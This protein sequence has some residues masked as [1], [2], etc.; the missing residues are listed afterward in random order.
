MELRPDE[1]GKVLSGERG[2]RGSLCIGHCPV[3]VLKWKHCLGSWRDWA[4]N[5]RPGRPCSFSWTD[6]TQH[7]VIPRQLSWPGSNIKQF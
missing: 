7:L 1:R 5:K 6:E 4:L 3:S 2:Q